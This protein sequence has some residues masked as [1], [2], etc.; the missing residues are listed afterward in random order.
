LEQLELKQKLEILFAQVFLVEDS[1]STK[2]LQNSVLCNLQV[3][4]MLG[5]RRVA[6]C[7]FSPSPVPF[8][9]LAQQIR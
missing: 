6:S 3:Y 8:F 9:F 7:L 2:R 1:I 5:S 4:F